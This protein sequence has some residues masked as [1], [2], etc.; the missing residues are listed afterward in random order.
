MHMLF[1]Y[2]DQIYKI[3]SFILINPLIYLKPEKGTP[4]GR[5]FPV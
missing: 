2:I 4:V 5:I 3:F 1:L